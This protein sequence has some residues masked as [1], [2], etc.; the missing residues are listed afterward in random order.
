MRL[1]DAL[2]TRCPV[3]V[4]LTAREA[5]RAESG[6]LIEVLADDP[7]VL[8]DLPAWCFEHGH[9]LVSIESDADELRAVVRVA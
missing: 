8:V 9:A 6:D 2:G 4:T 7:M 1:V 5:A 3:P